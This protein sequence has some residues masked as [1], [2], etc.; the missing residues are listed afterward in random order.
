MGHTAIRIAQRC[1]VVLIAL[2]LL[3]GCASNN[4]GAK[5]QSAAPTPTPTP[6][7]QSSPTGG[8]S[9]CDANTLQNGKAPPLVTLDS[10]SFHPGFDVGFYGHNFQP[11]EA[12]NVVLGT[13]KSTPQSQANQSL[14]TAYANKGGDLAGVAHIAMMPP[15]NYRLFFE[16]QQCTN[17]INI[18]LLKFTP[19]VV[20]DNY[21]PYPHYRMGF[22]GQD[23]APNEQVQVYLNSQDSQPI[24]Q[25]QADNSGQFAQNQVWDVGDL[26]G[27]NTLIFVGTTSKMI[28]SVNF[29]VLTPQ[30]NG[31]IDTMLS[32][33][34]TAPHVEEH[35]GGAALFSSASTVSA[36]AHDAPV[37]SFSLLAIDPAI[38]VVGLL[39]FWLLLSVTLM[40]LCSLDSF[41]RSPHLPWPS[42]QTD[43][44]THA[45]TEASAATAAPAQWARLH[46]RGL[47][48]PGMQVSSRTERGQTRDDQE[49]EDNFL[50]ITGTRR[51]LGQAEPFA[52]LVVADSVGHYANGQSAGHKT[53][54]TIFQSLVPYLIQENAP[55]DDLAAH[56]EHALQGANRLLYWQN[57]RESA[58]TQ[59]S[60]TAALVSRQMAYICNIG[61]S[62]T[63]VLPAGAPLRRVTTDH[64]IIE[65]WVAAGIKLRDD[66]SPP[67][68]QSRL[69]RSLGQHPDAHIDTF[70]LPVDAGDQLLLCSN[71]LWESLADADLETMMQQAS[72][73]APASNTLVEQAKTRGSFDNI[74][75]IM[76]KLAA[77]APSST[78]P[79]IDNIASGSSHLSRQHVP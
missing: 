12:V 54:H 43:S 10:Y 3:V 66:T 45:K 28:V 32:H 46:Q 67:Q 24:A 79:G 27:D 39:A 55:H 25:M 9:P 78:Q 4:Q 51:E 57:Q 68:R 69:Y 19:W 71:G 63:Y 76:M 59:C 73:S 2:A 77:T 22:H 75:A 26:S 13:E 52:L 47:P 50:A 14:T 36:F 7:V 48:T 5:R 72:D 44:L 17:T 8:A 62:R 31:Q 21:A 58:N 74:T 16:G 64:S 34:F 49:K 53:I 40:V 23:F 61:N 56:L 38:L 11:G 35:R 70:R 18:I 60:V 65:R 33:A 15:G 1:A 37:G 42:K 41:P 29:T 30:P 20:L 6:P